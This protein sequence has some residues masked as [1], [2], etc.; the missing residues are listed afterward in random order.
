M[1]YTSVYGEIAIQAYHDG[2]RP[3]A[4]ATIWGIYQVTKHPD[5]WCPDGVYRL[6]KDGMTKREAVRHLAEVAEQAVQL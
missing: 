6:L 5:R 2:G 4:K 1:V 3:S